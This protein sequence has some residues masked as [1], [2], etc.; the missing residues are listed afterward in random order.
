MLGDLA[1]LGVV[2]AE[3][4]AAF[5]ARVTATGYADRQALPAE[6]SGTTMVPEELRVP[7]VEWALA[8]DTHPAA[9]L[10][11][12]FQHLL[13]VPRAVIDRALGKDAR[14]WLVEGGVLLGESGPLPPPLLLVVAPAAVPLCVPGA[15]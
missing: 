11:L 1:C 13:P 10:A 14:A 12:L 2:T 15:R 4:S 7:L 3:R 6:A 9:G 5:R 8:R